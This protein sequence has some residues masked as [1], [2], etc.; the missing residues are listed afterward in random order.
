MIRGA[1]SEVEKAFINA[2]FGKWEDTF[3]QEITKNQILGKTAKVK[4][5]YQEKY[6][7]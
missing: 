7:E 1:F 5:I 6:Q 3:Y 4:E 2:V